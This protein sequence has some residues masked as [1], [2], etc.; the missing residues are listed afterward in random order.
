M[1]QIK[2]EPVDYEYKPSVMTSP[3]VFN[4]GAVAPLQ[5]TVQ[6][7]V[8]PTVG[9]V[10]PIS[11]NLADLQNA[12]KVAVDGNMIRQVLESKGQTQGFTTGALHPPQQ[13]LISAISLPIVGQDGNA[14]III[15]YSLD[16]S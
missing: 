15:N 6:A 8:L 2:T 14:K 12:L 11:I 10:S 7:V 4:G 9:L 3:G 1:N 5:G 16:R 13:Q